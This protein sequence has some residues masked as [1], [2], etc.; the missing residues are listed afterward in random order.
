MC[1]GIS[2]QYQNLLVFFYILVYVIVFQEV[3]DECGKPKVTSTTIPALA[4]PSL[5]HEV[6]IWHY[7]HICCISRVNVIDILH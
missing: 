1:W 7:D 2:M 5:F 3:V 6:C 4:S